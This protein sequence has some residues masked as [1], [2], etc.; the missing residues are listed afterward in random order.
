MGENPAK[1]TKGQPHSPYHSAIRANF[2]SVKPGTYSIEIDLYAVPCK[3]SNPISCQSPKNRSNR[4]NRGKIERFSQ[5]AQAER[6]EKYV[7]RNGKETRFRKRK[8]CK[9]GSGGL[10]FREGKCPVVNFSDRV[11]QTITFLD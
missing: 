6:Y 9:P 7:G 5:C 11:I 4:A 8:N 1:K 10:L 3:M 2:S